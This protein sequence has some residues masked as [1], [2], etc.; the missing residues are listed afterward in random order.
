MISAVLDC[1]G[2]D[3]GKKWLAVCVL[4]DLPMGRAGRNPRV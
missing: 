2:I 4:G 3:A 1:A